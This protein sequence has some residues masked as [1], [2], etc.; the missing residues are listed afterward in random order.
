[1][2]DYTF[3]YTTIA[4]PG[5]L[6]AQEAIN[7]GYNVIVPCGGDGTIRSVCCQIAKHN[8]NNPDIEVGIV[9]LGTGNVLAH[10]LEI[11]ILDTDLAVRMVL[12]A[13]S[14]KFDVGLC[15]RK[16][17]AGFEHAFLVIAGAGFDANL[18]KRT[19]PKAKKIVGPFAYYYAGIKEA[20]RKKPTAELEVTTADDETLTTTSKLRTVMVGNCGRI[21]GFK[22]IPDAKY[23]D[24]ILDVAAVDTTAGLLGWMQLGTEIF[25]QNLGIENNSKYKIGRID[26]IPAKKVTIKFNHAQQ[27]QLDGDLIG[28]TK[29]VTFRV[30]KHAINLRF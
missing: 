18:V 2:T 19:N 20:F 21:P 11:P 8:A 13:K 27:V 10:N 4:N 23:D 29:C 5:N 1:M 15:E 16:E 17:D 24:G 6:Q 26:Q 30:I 3:K 7:E 9:P 22:L 14:K 12:H 25:M 28:H